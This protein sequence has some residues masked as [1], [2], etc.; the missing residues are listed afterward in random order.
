MNHDENY[1]YFL[2]YCADNDLDP[3]TEDYWAW[4]DDARESYYENRAEQER[5]ERLMMDELYGD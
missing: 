2:D 5:E 3:E 1:D 4:L